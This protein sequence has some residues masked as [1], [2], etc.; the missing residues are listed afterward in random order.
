VNAIAPVGAEGVDVMADGVL[1]HG[2]TAFGIGA[3]CIGNVKY[4]AQLNLLK[5]MLESN[6]KHYL[7]F[8]SAFE[9]ARNSL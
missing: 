1:I 9:I 7:D 3:L 8:L 5:L 4:N 6:E 2:T